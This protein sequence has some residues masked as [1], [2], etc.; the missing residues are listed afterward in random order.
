MFF[1]SCP[2]YILKPMDFAYTYCLMIFAQILL[3][4]C[5]VDLHENINV[6][7]WLFSE[8][9]FQ[10][11]SNLWFFTSWVN[12]INCIRNAL[13]LKCSPKL[14]M[15]TRQQ[16]LN[17]SRFNVH[18]LPYVWSLNWSH[19]STTKNWWMQWAS[20]ILNIGLIFLLRKHY[21]VI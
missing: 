10:L 9:I 18:M 2:F 16:F 15:M 7:C 14:C 1:F 13:L 12:N 8:V 20:F 6:S 11:I 17:L 19:D 4:F 3:K 21:E 5:D